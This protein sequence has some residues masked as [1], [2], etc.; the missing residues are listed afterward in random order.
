MTRFR[1]YLQFG[2]RNGETSTCALRSPGNG[3]RLAIT[4]PAEP[5]TVTNQRRLEASGCCCRFVRCVNDERRYVT[6][7]FF[8][9]LSRINGERAVALISTHSS[10]LRSNTLRLLLLL[11]LE[12]GATILI[13]RP[14][15]LA[16][17]CR[18]HKLIFALANSCSRAR[19]REQRETR[20]W[21]RVVLLLP[22]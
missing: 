19:E 6:V 18:A 2:K 15:Q 20:P 5:I 10:A 1:T 22:R 17:V 3:K 7:F 12:F 11:F 8:F 21:S 13:L 16:R 14:R 9:L 4:Q